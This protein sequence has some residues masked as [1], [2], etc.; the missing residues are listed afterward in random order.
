M[1][2]RDVPKSYGP[3]PMMERGR[4][5]GP[6]LYS[7][8]NLGRGWTFVL[9][10]GGSPFRLRRVPEDARPRVLRSFGAGRF[11]GAGKRL[12]QHSRDVVRRL[13]LSLISTAIETSSSSHGPT[14]EPTTKELRQGI[15]R[16][17]KRLDAVK[18]FDP[19]SVRER[20]KSPELTRAARPC[21]GGAG[22][23]VRAG[24]AGLQQV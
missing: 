20:F 13:F 2:H 1:A 4:N 19:I 15:D 9:G 7:P 6:H 24:F 11:A 10:L 12:T 8:R 18:K 21:R 14:H 23:H 5:R 22:Q 16:L 17:T 3:L